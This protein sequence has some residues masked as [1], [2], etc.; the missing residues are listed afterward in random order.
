[1][2]LFIISNTGKGKCYRINVFSFLDLCSS[3]SLDVY[4]CENIKYEINKNMSPFK[5]RHPCNFYG[6]PNITATRF[7]EEHERL[8]KK[9]EQKYDQ[10]RDQTEERRFIHSPEWRAMR[11]VKLAVDPLCQ[12]HLKKGF[13][14]AATMVHHIK[15]V[16]THPELRLVMENLESLCNPCHEEKEQKGRWGGRSKS[17]GIGA[18]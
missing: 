18:G 3:S 4:A 11:E 15:P 8:A 10:A 9:N 14:M 17:S 16:E 2:V 12:E 7:C 6:C 13:D 5:P 1:L